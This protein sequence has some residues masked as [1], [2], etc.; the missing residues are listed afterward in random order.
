MIRL[1]RTT[2]YALIALQHMSQKQAQDATAVTSA[3]EVS[4][5]FG[6]PFEITAKTL[7][8][9]KDTG[10]ILS[11]QG[12]KGGYLLQKNLSEITL[13]R[14]LEWMED[15]QQVVA[16]ATSPTPCEYSPKCVI[17]GPMVVLNDK[18]QKFLGEI[19][20]SD[21]ASEVP[22]LVQNQTTSRLTAGVNA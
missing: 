2:E 16:C 10:L 11:A 19:R 22:A 15:P 5:L 8:R 9:M 4:D 7:Q 18:I 17:N 6:L 21:L 3:R 14:F 1:N 13:A 20:L 12:A